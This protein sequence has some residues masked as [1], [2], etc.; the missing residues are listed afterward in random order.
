MFEKDGVEY[1]NRMESIDWR[2]SAAILGLIKF[3]EFGEKMGYGLKYAYDEDYIYYNIEDI[4]E[5]R[6]L[7]FAEDYFKEDMFH[8]FA[9]NELKFKNEFTDDDIKIINER[10]LGNT[11]LKKYF[12][13]NKF[14]GTNKDEIIDLISHHREEIVR[15]TF[16]NKTNLYRN[17]NN[18]NFLFN[19]K[20]DSCRVLGYYADMPKKGKSLSYNF[21][22]G[23][24]VIN[25]D[26]IFDFI[27]FGFVIGSDA[28]FINNNV[29]ISYIKDTNVTLKLKLDA[30]EQ[31]KGKK[32][33]AKNIL[34]NMLVESSDF[35]DYDV[36]V[37]VKKRK[38][39][40]FETLYIRK[41]SINI[42]SGIK[43]Y[44]KCHFAGKYKVNDNYYIDF[45]DRVIDAVLNMTNVTD[46]IQL[47]LKDDTANS[48]NK[49]NYLIDKL[50]ELNMMIAG[51]VDM[52]QDKEKNI[53][54]AKGCAFYITQNKL[55]NENK[56]KSYRTKLISALV[57]KDYKRYC[58]VLMQLANYIGIELDFAYNLFV[59][60]EKNEEIAYAFVN[61]LGATNKETKEA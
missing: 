52:Y 53:K 39:E 34:F 37:I 44:I 35:I 8:I 10:L 14:N 1:N 55:M 13:K 45:Q 2:Y 9:E 21:N 18:T 24:L 11:T 22:K 28:V 19:D 17:Y 56:I 29:N 7:R 5:E 40:F 26:F 3:F 43:K 60:F 59:D 25:D 15:E 51:G 33:S 54:S 16:R 48:S 50:I 20:K 23:K 27:P 4:T 57:F 30:E 36:E 42:F 12:S 58:D 41:E 32:L 61:G 38:Y 31:D 46:I 49:Y 47:L 6:F